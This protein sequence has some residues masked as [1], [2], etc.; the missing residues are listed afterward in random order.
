MSFDLPDSEFFKDAAERVL[1]TAAEAGLAYAA[2]TLASIPAWWAIPIA[3][4]VATAKT[5]VAKR[6]AP[7]KGASIAALPL[8]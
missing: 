4:L 8:G 5:W 7:D 2:V 1:W 6:L 3:G